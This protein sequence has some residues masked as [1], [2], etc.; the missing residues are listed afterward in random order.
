MLL[1][2]MTI[3]ITIKNV[4]LGIA[5][6]SKMTFSI[7]TLMLMTLGISIKNLK[8]GISTQPNNILYNDT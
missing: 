2:K 8:L 3:S 5:T 1:M 6:L 7:M 4:T